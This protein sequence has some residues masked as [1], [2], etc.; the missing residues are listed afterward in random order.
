MVCSVRRSFSVGG[1]SIQ[2]PVSIRRSV[3]KGVSF[4]TRTFHHR[5]DFL[6]RRLTIAG[7]SAKL[8]VV[9][10]ACAKALADDVDR[11]FASEHRKNKVFKCTPYCSLLTFV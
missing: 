5:E 4:S 11:R 6:Y 3:S 9:E 8:S 7:N 1:S 10:S 2:Y